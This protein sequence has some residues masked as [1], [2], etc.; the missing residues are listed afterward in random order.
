MT[1]DFKFDEKGE[2]ALIERMLSPDIALNPLK[3]V[4]T[5][6]PWGK[7]GT[8]LA[9]CRG[10]RKWQAQELY[11]IAEHNV[12]NQKRI[13]GGENPEPYNL[14]VSSGRGIGKSA[15]VSWIVLWLLSTQIGSAIIVTA[16]TEQQ[17]LSRTWPEIG[18][19]HSM[20]LNSHWF[21]R[22][23]TAIRPS[24]WLDRSLRDKTGRDT[25][26]YYAQAQLWSEEN[27]DAF[28][29]AHN[30]NGIALLMD[31]ASG[32]PSSIWDVSEGFF[33]EPIFC[34]YWIV[35]S[36]PS[37]KKGEGEFYNCFHRNKELW[38]RRIIDGRTVEGIDTAV[39]DRLVK[40][41]GE[42]SDVVRVEVKGQFPKTGSNQL[43][44][45]YIV[46]QAAKRTAENRFI[47]G[48]AKIMGVDVARHGDDK[49]VIQKRQGAFAFEP[50][51]LDQM[52]NMQVAGIVAGEIE[53]W[54]ADGCIVDVGG[55]QGVID[56]LRQLGYAVL[57]VNS[58]SRADRKE[59][60]QNKRI[61]M[62]EKMKDWLMEGGIIP[63]HQA[64][65][66]D[67]TEPTFYYN[68]TTN[69][70]TL[71]NI[72]MIKARLG[73]SPDFASALA[74]TFAFSIFAGQ[75]LAGAKG[76]VVDSYDIHRIP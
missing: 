52:D 7:T 11:R 25:A 51:E 26:Y 39:Y 74:F 53:S 14:A 76:E 28:R 63:D 24:A 6:Y 48:E 55:G 5:A 56:R 27:P 36:N 43:I 31:E 67:L 21:K 10:P 73:R 2:I 44:S 54:E 42:D 37:P 47:E 4:M 50:I 66:E 9:R 38:N 32:I 8:P 12:R 1:D 33:T 13:A 68:Q 69:R 75:N 35:F 30:M 70:K 3:F 34:R 29:G 20:M 59:V 23:A 71:E 65:K 62:W 72:E 22:T 19:W 61:E 46:E 40:K 49:T 17:L 60:Y 58:G 15:I 57:E 64:L 18:K 16:N 41:H 45:W